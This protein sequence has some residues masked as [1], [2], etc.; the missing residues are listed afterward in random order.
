M[1]KIMMSAKLWCDHAEGLELDLR[2]WELDVGELERTS[3]TAL[4]DEIKYTVMM[5]MTPMFLRNNEQLD[6]SVLLLFPKL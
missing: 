4:T 2:V 5:N 3:G 1:Q 6:T